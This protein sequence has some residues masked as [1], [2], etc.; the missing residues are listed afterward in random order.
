M[1]IMNGGAD[2]G[3]RCNA[4]DKGSTVVTFKAFVVTMGP[5]RIM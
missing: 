5:M 1:L 2:E 3:K 4:G